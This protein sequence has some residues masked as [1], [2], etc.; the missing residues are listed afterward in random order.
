MKKL[1]FTLCVL[2]IWGVT[3]VSAQTMKITGTVTGASDGLT[4]PGVSIVVKGTTAG[5]TTN[6][7]GKYELNA[8]TNANELVFSFIGMK[9]LEVPINGRAVIDV[10]MELETQTVEE[11]VVV[12]YGTKLK[13]DLTGSISKVQA[14]EI[15]NLPVPTFETAIQGRTAGVFI[16]NSSGKLGEG[17]RIRVRGTSSISADN[18]PIYVV[19]GMVVT[20]QS[21]GASSNSPTN[22]MADINPNDIESIN[23]LKDASAAAIYG[24]RAAN[25]V[26]LITTK[27]GKSGKTV[28][29]VGYQTGFSTPTHKVDMMNADQYRKY[30]TN[31]LVAEYGISKEDAVSYLE[32]IIP[33]FSG[34]VNGTDTI[35]YDTNWQDEAFQRGNLNQLEVSATG[36][37]EKTQFFTGLTYNDQAGI[38]LGNKL[39]RISGRL[40]I[41][42]QATKRLKLGMNLGLSRSESHRVPND[43]AFANPLQMISLPPVQPK[44]DPENPK[45]LYKQTIYENG[46]IPAKYNK[47][48]TVVLRNIG[49]LY[50]AYEF[51]P[52]LVWKSEFGID[53][54]SQ[55][56]DNYASK[57]TNDGAPT[58]LADS[59]TV[60]V[61]NASTDNY[62]TFNKD[63]S[64]NQ[65]LE[66]VGGITYQQSNTSTNWVQARGFPDDRFTTIASASEV[67]FFTS[68]ETG[69]KYM[70]YFS[71]ANYK[72][73]DKY[74]LTLSGRMD[75][76]SR[77][78]SNNRYGF[79]PAGS[80]GWVISKENFM[81]NL[82]SVSF[83]KLRASCG[84]TGNSEIN[85]FA[86]LSLYSASSYT[87]SPSITPVQLPSPDLKWE[88]TTQTDI[89]LDYGFFNNRISGEI[90]VYY[91][92]TKDLLLYKDLP[93]TSGFTSFYRNVG[94]L[95]NKGLEFVINTNNLTGKL[96][97]STSFNLG[98]NRNKI[99][100]LDGPSIQ[101]GNT[102]TG[103]NIAMKNQPLGVFYLPKYAGVAPS[104]VIGGNP[105]GS[106][107]NGGDALYYVE[108]GSKNITS[109][110]ALAD[111]QIVG[112][113]NPDFY[114]GIYNS[115]TYKDWE[116]NFLFQFV[117][118]ND[119]YKSFGQWAQSNG[120]NLD[121][122]TVDQVDGWKKD[123]D[124]TDVPRAEWDYKNGSRPSSRYL[125]NGSY[126]RLKSLNLSYTLPKRITDK[127]N[128][129]SLRV[130]L[131]ASN[132]WTLTKYT[133]WDPEVNYTGTGRSQTNTNLIQ[134]SEF[135]SAPQSKTITLGV[136]LSF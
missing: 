11:V 103:N 65:N 17:M 75:G 88:T 128:L 83:L 31:M 99:L 82:K 111:A 126:L 30:F 59:R 76:S 37:T 68:T 4:L 78:G 71:R 74:L 18:Q 105:D 42:N 122:Q 113:P 12:G 54:L 69:Y 67:A 20:S 15:E 100:N 44:Y 35:K 28:I 43:N 70:S 63:I 13:R 116:F 94:S 29:N 32:S 106:D 8:P 5:T 95:E 115:F 131:T 108:A 46:L 104:T 38:L 66:V 9:T 49:G 124:I 86:S 48:K 19:D 119:I 114:G 51:I 81:S 3:L 39:N 40:N 97:W 26:V 47:D 7:D 16:E 87:T 56:E 53:L 133:G 109:N 79:F 134:G 129:A 77:F 80:V 121:N 136:K 90:D 25:G 14:K 110:Y 52:G 118:G 58:G 84:Q 41:D 91:K 101:A 72:L 27:H 130:Y 117:V 50:A 120:Y 24:S 10:V 55:R 92:K 23:I 45:E 112:D 36:G 33:Y 6:I 62:L 34:Y 1:F 127:V 102:S 123:G 135:Y 2:S 89:G 73:N 98:L 132:L 125:E 96:Q 61:V 64:S 60:Q 22:P 93:A 85:N 107:I 57:K 21:Q